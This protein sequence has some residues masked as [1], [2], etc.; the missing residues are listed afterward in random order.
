MAL[1]KANNRMIDG[2]TVNVLD[3]GATGDG[4]TDDTAAIQAAINYAATSNS[5]KVFF[6]AGH[7]IVTTLYDHYDAVNNP[8]FPNGNYLDGRITLEGEQAVSRP[9]L[10]FTSSNYRGTLIET[11]SATGPALLLG[12]GDG[13]SAATARRQTVRNMAFLGTCTG[14]VVE[15]DAATEHTLLENLTIANKG[16]VNGKGLY[17]HT[18]FYQSTIRNVDI[19]S[20]GTGGNGLVC[21]V[22][23]L[24]LFDTVNV[25]NCGGTAWVLGTAS[26][27]AGNLGF[28]TGNSFINCQGRNSLNGLEIKG[29]RSNLF[30]GWWL[31]QNDGDFDIKIHENASNCTF[32]G[33]LLISTELSV[34]SM[35]IGGNSGTSYRDACRGIKLQGMSFQFCGPT[36]TQAGIR[37]YASCLDLTVE[38]CS[39]KNNGG[40][41]IIVDTTD[42]VTPTVLIDCDWNPVGA[43]SE[44]ATGSRVVD[45]TGASSPWLVRGLNSTD[46]TGTITADLDMSTWTHLP[47]TIFCS[48]GTN[49][50]V[51]LPTDTSNFIG[52][53]IALRKSLAGNTLTVTGNI[54]GAASVSA[55]ADESVTTLIAM[56]GSL[57][58]QLS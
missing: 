23:S 22:A 27:G 40:K 12:N 16:G 1:T 17:I 21:E 58:G 43:T 52:K 11:T 35:V 48:T 7:Y 15:L 25:T 10:L 29:G 32:Q 56:G 19:F 55:T 9:N 49:I 53:T 54:N 2:A 50:N 57:Y 30:S 5:G 28:G 20:N 33:M 34:A 24:V 37:K 39:F 46:F 18:S 42:G 38:K 13:A 31:E 36:S 47:D 45:Q 4:T 41:G 14:S 8:D 6:P 44:I 51:T 3:F 26:T